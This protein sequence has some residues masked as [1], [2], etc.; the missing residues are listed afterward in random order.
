MAL[1]LFEGVGVVKRLFVCGEQHP[2]WGA[3]FA[4]FATKKP[5]LL[6]SLRLLHRFFSQTKCF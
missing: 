6:A 2:I 3:S 5:A 4:L 1:G